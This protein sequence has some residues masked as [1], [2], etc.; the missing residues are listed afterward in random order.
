MFLNVWDKI[1][2]TGPS[3]Y[4][5]P[6]LPFSYLYGE[7]VNNYFHTKITLAIVGTRMDKQAQSDTELI[8]LEPC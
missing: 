1:I 2:P 8:I 6:Y 5:R 4:L 7:Y 3:Q